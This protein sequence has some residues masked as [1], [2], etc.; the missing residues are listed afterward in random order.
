[1]TPCSQFDVI[2]NW[3][4]LL[5]NIATILGAVSVITAVFVLMKNRL[6]KR[7]LKIDF[8]LIN[9]SILNTDLRTFTFDCDISNFTDKEFFITKIILQIENNDYE[10]QHYKNAAFPHVPLAYEIKNLP[11]ASHEAKTLRCFI[12]VPVKTKVPKRA[13]VKIYSTER[14]LILPVIFIRRDRAE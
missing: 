13:K 5:A 2:L 1:M 3:T 10:L 12:D 11:I 9:N 7:T 14:N 8:T 4:S 6:S